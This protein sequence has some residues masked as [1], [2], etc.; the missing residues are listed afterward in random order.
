ML[1]PYNPCDDCKQKKMCDKCAM[2]FAKENYHRALTKI[3]ELSNEL[4][5]K[6]TILV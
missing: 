1:T 4:G 3:V 2:T 6:V 5:K